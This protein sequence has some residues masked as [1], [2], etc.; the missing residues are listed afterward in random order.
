MTDLTFKQIP[1]SKM[2][3]LWARYRGVVQNYASL[4]SGSIGRL[5]F[6]LVYFLVLANTLSVAAFGI[7][8]AASAM[9]VVLSRVSGLGFSSPLYRI[10]TVK[11]QLIGAYLGGYIGCFVLSLP[12]VALLG[13]IAYETV[14]AG[15][16]T[17]LAFCLMMVSEI[18]LWRSAEII[19]IINNGLR[20]FGLGATLT[21]LGT[22]IR[23]C[24]ALA[25]WKLATDQSVEMWAWFYM[26][27]NALSFLLICIFGRIKSR[28]C[29]VWKLYPRRMRDAL[30]V[31][32]A[33][34]IFYAQME[35]DK[36]LMLA[37]AGGEVTGI[38]AVMMRLVD[39]TA[40]PLRAFN[41]LLVQTLMKTPDLM[42]SWKRRF[43]MEGGIALVSTLALGAAAFLLWIKPTLLGNNIALVAPVLMFALA[44]P[45]TRNIVEY[46]S[47]L[48]YAR[49][50]TFARVGLLALLGAM[51]A[52]LMMQFIQPN[53]SGVT[54]IL[55]MSAV[56]GA[57]YLVSAFF[58]YRL[59]N[60]PAA[61]I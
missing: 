19:I 5:V 14:F 13:Y 48:L 56:F 29:F 8:A 6:S 1:A 50:Q 35:L 30:S 36:V 58:T 7:V 22:F 12:L 46:H 26:A 51:K 37:L 28:I 43:A 34:I 27:A 32:S 17:V 2:A 52:L 57:L 9:G 3:S 41:T 42:A 39:L 59:I 60:K 38:Y 33:E 45:A 25:F 4:L 21:I 40:M 49:G 20:R 54:L 44:I 11:P 55:W 16:L 47:E 53:I 24:A 15:Q 61:R 31:A 10:A 23:M 18:L